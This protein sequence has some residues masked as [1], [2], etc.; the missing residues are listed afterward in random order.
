[1]DVPLNPL[2]AVPTA[3]SVA[4]TASG[5]VIPRRSTGVSDNE[6]G[7]VVVL[8]LDLGGKIGVKCTNDSCESPNSNN[9]Q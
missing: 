4:A 6:G 3:V 5:A 8:W 7:S 2:N 1:M 9:T